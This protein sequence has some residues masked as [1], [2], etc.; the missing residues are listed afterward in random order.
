MPRPSSKPARSRTFAAVLSALLVVTLVAAPACRSRAAARE[1][2][3]ASRLKPTEARVHAVVGRTLVMPVTVEGSITP[4]ATIRARLDDGRRITASIC[5]IGLAPELIRSSWLPPAGLWSVT[6]ASASKLPAGRGTWAVVADLPPDAIGQG[7]WLGTQRAS[8]NWLPSPDLIAPDEWRS[9]LGEA[10]ADPTLLRLAESESRSPVLRWRHRLLTD[11]LSPAASAPHPFPDPVLE[12]LARQIEA[13]WQVALAALSAADPYTAD[14]VKRRLVATVRLAPEQTVPAWSLDESDLDTLLSDLLNSRLQPAQQVERAKAWLS[15][16][17]SG[18]AW[19]VDDAG[20]R[21]GVTGQSAATFGVANLTDRD[22][23]A[24]ATGTPSWLIEPAADLAM[25]PAWASAN[26]LAALAPEQGASPPRSPS[27][28]IDIHLGGWFATRPTFIYPIPAAPPGARLEPFRREWDL[29]SWSSGLPPAPIEPEWDAAALLYRE[30]T[31][32][33]TA[34]WSVFIECRSPAIGEDEVVRIWLGP[35]GAPTAIINAR[36]NGAVQDEVGQRRRGDGTVPGAT[37]SRVGDVWSARIPIHARCIESDG[38][39]R[40]GLQRTDALTRRT[41]WPRPMLPWQNEPG[42][43]SI[44][45]RAWG[46]LET[47]RVDRGR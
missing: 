41:S 27:L 10:A 26:V 5:W 30:S 45:T 32:D 33:G 38:T 3:L 25:V 2:R 44:N 37:I 9:P 23:L 21:E 14:L 39:I 17:P 28:P 16:Q 18:I 20:T 36:S 7:L 22:S 6:P 34:A 35:F 46:G 40:I 43:M 31:S 8:L 4:S 13:R 12:S 42:R 47:P 19:V 11:G 24:W 15:A 29:A 1:T